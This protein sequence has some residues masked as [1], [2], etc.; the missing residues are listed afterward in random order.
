M[1]RSILQRNIVHGCGGGKRPGFSQLRSRRLWA[2]T[3]D[4]L[5]D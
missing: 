3:I 1:Q 4:R 5:A 2:Q